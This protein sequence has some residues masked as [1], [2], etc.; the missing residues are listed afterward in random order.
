MDIFLL[1]LIIFLL[2]CI[3]ILYGF[4]AKAYICHLR[5]FKYLKEADYAEWRRLRSLGSGKYVGAQNFDKLLTYIK[6]NAG[7]EDLKILRFKD[8]MRFCFR[9]LKIIGLSILVDI[10][11]I[12]FY[13]TF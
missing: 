9:M 2:I 10:V 7:E 12:F 13:T 1:A 11:I 3:A 4:F 8:E 5:F 6:S